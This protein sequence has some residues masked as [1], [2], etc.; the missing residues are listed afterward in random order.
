MESTIENA[1]ILIASEKIKERQDGI[2]RYREAF[3]D[4]RVLQNLPDVLDA[5]DLRLGKP[6]W[7]S[8]FQSIFDAMIQERTTYLKSISKPSASGAIGDAAIRRVGELARLIAWMTDKAQQRIGRKTSR[9]ILAHLTQTLQTEKGQVLEAILPHYLR[10]LKTLLSWDPHAQHVDE[11]GWKDGVSVCW[12]LLLGDA[13][14]DR[15]EAAEDVALASITPD[16]KSG[17]RSSTGVAVFL[18]NQA[19]TDAFVC[20]EALYGSCS[21][22]LIGSSEE[23]FGIHLLARYVRYF[24]E[25]RQEAASSLYTMTSLNVLLHVLQINE[26]AFS[27]KFAGIVWSTLLRLLETKSPCLKEQVLIAFDLLLP[28]LAT[29]LPIV[30]TSASAEAMRM[31]ARADVHLQLQ[32]LQSALLNEPRSRSG[33]KPLHLD[34]ISFRSGLQPKSNPR[35][36]FETNLLATSS[37]FEAVNAPEWLALEVLADTT[38]FMNDMTPSSFAFVV[39]DAEG[40]DGSVVPPTLSGNRTNKRPRCGRQG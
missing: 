1:A 8:S 20:L 5:R 37:R 16:V 6:C 28:L 39:T 10:A 29:P 36:A 12:N 3:S 25:H 19:V 7:I 38:N 11:K 22:I 4:S 13:P 26:R 15:I 2:S 24:S 32:Q 30:D 33:L 35:Q 27:T 14:K 31:Q 23:R 21:A 34:T 9:A 17:S 18:S 40:R